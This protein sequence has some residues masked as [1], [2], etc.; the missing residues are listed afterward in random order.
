M[1]THQGLKS[2]F[3]FYEV[4]PTVHGC[5]LALV[6]SLVVENLNSDHL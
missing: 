6:R 2:S 3:N 5:R 1:L 4:Q